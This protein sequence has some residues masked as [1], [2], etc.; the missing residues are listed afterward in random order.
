MLLC[1][2][3][4]QSYVHNNTGSNDVVWRLHNSNANVNANGNLLKIAHYN[5][6]TTHVPSQNSGFQ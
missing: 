6:G 5:D 2:C 3:E 1:A 4:V